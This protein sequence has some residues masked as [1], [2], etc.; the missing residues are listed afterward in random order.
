MQLLASEEYGLRCLLRVA[1]AA[2]AGKPVPIAAVAAS[3]GLGAEYAAKL[4]RMLRLGDLVESV[5]GAEGGYRL[6]RPAREITLWSALQALG[7]EFFTAGFCACHAGRRQHCV[8]VT[9]CSL[10][11]LWAALQAGVRE[12]LEGISLADLQRDERSMV[13]WIDEAGA[14]DVGKHFIGV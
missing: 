9:D 1:A 3:E 11:P 13:V 2:K 6:A 10:R 14:I 5:R 12:S 4:L 7:G 8:R